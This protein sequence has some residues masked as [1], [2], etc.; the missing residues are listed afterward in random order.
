MYV[1]YHDEE[2]GVPIHDDRLLF[3][4]LTLETFQAGLSWIT[5]LR[6]REHFRTAFAS[7]DA[8]RV[9]RFNNADLERLMLDS[10]IIRNRAKVGAAINNAQAFIRL[11][12]EKGSF[13]NY[14]WNFVDGKPM[15]NHFK[16]QGEVPAN[17][18]L[19]DQISADL[20]R[21]G[22]QF[23]GSTVIYSHM[24]ATG[25]VNDHLVF[26]PRHRELQ[27]SMGQ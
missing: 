22:F 2:W 5:V 21:R 3:E 24:Q 20:K 15:V 12:D 19:S 25:M 23:V 8:N 9:A 6:K 27:E 4:F 14:I 10:G 26:C 1:R 17:T 11:Q 13:D 16:N 7:F 18:A